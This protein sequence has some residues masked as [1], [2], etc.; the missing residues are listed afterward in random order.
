MDIKKA[1]AID[2]AKEML[3]DGETVDYIMRETRL[4]L[5]DIKKIQT[6][7]SKHF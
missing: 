7:I 6:E 4:R 1:G 2:K 5:K 3:L